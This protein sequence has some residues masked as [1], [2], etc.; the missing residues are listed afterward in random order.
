MENLHTDDTKEDILK[1][2]FLNTFEKEP[3]EIEKLPG[4]GSNR[5]YF[6]LKDHFRSVIGVSGEDVKENEAFLSLDKVFGKEGIRVPHI[7][8]VSQNRKFYLQ[9]DLG[10]VNLLNLFETESKLVYA[11]KA[12]E[13]LV[14]IQLT[15]KDKWGKAVFNRPFSPRLVRWDLNYF[16][17][18]F[19]KI[20]GI[21]FDEEKLEDDFEK[22][23]QGLTDSGM[24]KGLMYRDF[25]SR[26]IL[27]HEGELWYIDFQGARSGPLVYDAV[28]LIWQAKAPFNIEDKQ[29]LQRYYCKILGEKI[30]ELAE[31]IS[32]QFDKMIVFRTLQ[33]M[34]AYGFRGLVEKKSHFLESIPKVVDNLIYLRQTGFLDELEEIKKVSQRIEEWN[35]RR[36]NTVPEEGVLTLRVGSFSYKKGYPEDTSGNGGGF[37]FD[38]RALPNPGRFDE[39]KKLNGLDKK[40]KDFLKE[41]SE[42]EKFI[43]D[44]I[45]IVKP[46]IERYLQRGFTSLQVGFGCTGGQHRSVY[47]AEKFVDGL[48]Q[49]FPD[50][51]ILVQHR[52]QNLTWSL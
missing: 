24:I 20:A 29:A 32:R 43:Q 47:C 21:E 15:P 30:S 40:V 45:E 41:Y 23:T 16:K 11:K 48:K 33:V 38:C 37:M 28:S 26:N 5:Q 36:K 27:F 52:E 39:Y 8:N 46:S 35:E 19:L 51:K 6:R 34:G 9:Q 4:G 14:K 25:Q 31:E 7:Y 18:D 2:L 42:V 3:Y 49:I 1:G 10:D 22:I 44:C 50:I 17:Y 13:D 12:L